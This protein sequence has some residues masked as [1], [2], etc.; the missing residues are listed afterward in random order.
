MIPKISRVISAPVFIVTLM[1][2]PVA[3]SAQGVWA[4]PDTPSGQS[5]SSSVGALQMM[6]DE[7]RGQID[8]AERKGS[9]HPR[10]L[11]DLRDLANRYQRPA[12][13]EVLGDNFSDGNYTAHPHWTVTSGDFYIEKGY[14]LRSTVVSA[15]QSAP[16][17][18][19]PK[20][21]AVAILGMILKK[22]LKQKPLEQKA[23][24]AAAASIH[25][26]AKIANAFTMRLTIYSTRTPAILE[27]GPYQGALR[28]RGYRLL[29]RAGSGGSSLRLIRVSSRGSEVLAISTRPVNLEDRRPHEVIWTRSV[30]GDMT[31]SIDG[32]EKIR[33]TDREV[34]GPFDG[35]RMINR[36]GDYILKS[37]SVFD[38]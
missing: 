2:A 17:S 36:G 23:D 8:N 15:P 33:T 22:A 29:Y 35:F 28:S 30:T 31:V 16:K 10:F 37:I 38:M 4:N 11:Q 34:R 1:L 26:A 25:V 20:D 18:A 12:R 6:I 5:G 24:T 14:G 7:L 32:G 13:V 9:A 21:R 3:G 19:R 27:M